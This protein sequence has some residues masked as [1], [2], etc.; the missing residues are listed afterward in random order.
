MRQGLVAVQIATCA[1]LLV[2][3]G[4]FLRTLREGLT[5]DLG[6][7]TEGVALAQFRLGLLQYDPADAIV[8]VDRLRDRLGQLPGVD[9]VSVSTKVPLAPGTGIG[10][11]ATVDGYELIADADVAISYA[12]TFPPA[13]S[14]A[15]TAPAVA[16]IPCKLT[17]LSNSPAPY[18]VTPAL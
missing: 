14:I 2:G 7:R 6:V 11:F 9:A 5:A 4:L 17:A 15:T 16:D 13:A 1:V 10:F 3:S 12:S 8:F 18:S